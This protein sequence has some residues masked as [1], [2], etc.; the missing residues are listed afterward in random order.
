[1][2]INF[3]FLDDIREGGYINVGTSP[4]EKLATDVY[5]QGS[6]IDLTWLCENDSVDEIIA[7]HTLSHIPNEK[8][9]KTLKNWFNKLQKNGVLKIA[10]IDLYL[11]SKAFVD[12]Q[13]DINQF[14]GCLWGV[15]EDKRLSS[16]DADSLC[17]LLETVGFV[18]SIKRYD[19]TSFYVEA[20][21]Q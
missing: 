2:K 8:L 10:I 18:I 17:E 13:I 15:E 14:L 16:I 7:M 4:K 6:I 3:C 20:K 19:G 5:K 11:T 1:M 12:S 21:K 9:T